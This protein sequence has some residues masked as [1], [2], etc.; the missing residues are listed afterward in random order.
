M[1]TLRRARTEVVVAAICA[2]WAAGFYAP[3]GAAALAVAPLL[4]LAVVPFRRHPEAAGLAVLGATLLGAAAGV[5]AENPGGLAAGFTV[6]YALG[7]YADRR[8]LLVVAAL[9]AGL[10]VP[11]GPA[12]IDLVFVGIVLGAT[13][14]CGRLV[15][16]RTEAAK[17]A[18]ARA[19]EL[20]ARDPAE[21]A[22]RVMAEERARLAG[23]ALG[24]VRRAVAAMQ[25]DAL[26]AE[27][28][29][30]PV[31]L[32]AV[33]AGGR[34]AVTDL[35]R[36]LGLLRAEDE[37]AGNTRAE[38]RTRASAAKRRRHIPRADVLTAMG[39]AALC[40]AETAAFDLSRPTASVLLTLVLVA[41]VTLR[42]FDALLACALATAPSGLAAALGAPLVYGVAVAATLGLLS[43]SAGTDGRPYAL[44]VLGLLATVS[45]AVVS[46]DE[47]GNEGILLVVFALPAVA[48]YL[49][50]ARGRERQ[51]SELAAA[52]LHAAQEVAA[53]HAAR[54]ERLRLARE[55]HD[56]ASHA[57]GVMVLQ[58]GAAVALRER[59]A[60]AAR[61]AVRT[62]QRAGAEAMT[63]LD[64]LFGILDAGA[65]GPPGLATPAAELD[66][67]AA[68]RELVDRMRGAGLELRLVLPGSL[69]P[70]GDVAAT[71]LRIVQEALTNAVRHAAGSRVTVELGEADGE[72]LVEVSDDGPGA[73]PHEP[74]FGLIGLTER[75]RA[76]GGDLT[77]GSRTGGGFAVSAR[78]PAERTGAP[79]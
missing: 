14:T 29:L 11:W 8:G 72:L 12:A 9:T 70:D 69:D 31:A 41:C 49:W 19:A 68:V 66:F 28:T 60:D 22:A 34:T 44:G 55:L 59:D 63:E 75:V 56:V 1:S 15:R 46:A 32:A 27:A 35:R 23:E 67:T 61:A 74:G 42:R 17:S 3:E 43:W 76:L 36:L 47:P 62:L 6:A 53:E 4:G 64:G 21:L 78:L 77:A 30:D 24:V 54:T 73:S 52:A 79:A 48:G 40:A 58:A 25:R 71:A 45:V 18:A 7:R 50:G 33:Q 16:R 13:W 51:A 10:V 39:L 26:S 37:D 65:V 2:G 57:V 38:A 20:A 5:P